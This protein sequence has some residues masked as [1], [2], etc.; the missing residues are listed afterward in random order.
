[1]TDCFECIHFYV[2]FDTHFQGCKLDLDGK[3]QIKEEYWDGECPFFEPREDD[4]YRE[5]DEE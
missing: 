2:E 3:Q 4:Y 1:M 5:D